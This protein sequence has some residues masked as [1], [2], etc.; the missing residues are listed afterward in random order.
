MKRTITKVSTNTILRLR[1]PEATIELIKLHKTDGD[2]SAISKEIFGDNTQRQLVKV[3][4][5]N[6]EGRERVVNGI[7]KFYNKKANAVKSFS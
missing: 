3:A 7:V 1:I 2:F 5:E 6:G 4:I